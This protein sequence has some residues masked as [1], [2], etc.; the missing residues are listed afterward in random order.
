MVSIRFAKVLIF[1]GFPTAKPHEYEKMFCFPFGNPPLVPSF[2]SC[3]V[4][5]F[6]IPLKI[7]AKKGRLFRK[8]S[9]KLRRK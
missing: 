5:L 1:S 2:H 4:F 7:L 6:A 8:F 9:C 3:L